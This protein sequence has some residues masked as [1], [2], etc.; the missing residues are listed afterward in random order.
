MRNGVTVRVLTV[1]CGVSVAL[2][3]G[4]CSDSSSATPK[5]QKRLHELFGDADTTERMREAKTVLAYR[6]AGRPREDLTAKVQ[7]RVKSGESIGI[8]PILDGP[9]PMSRQD[10]NE[11]LAILFNARNLS[12]AGPDC[13][14]EPGIALRFQVDEE[15][16]DVL[17]CFKCNQI[18]VIRGKK[19]TFEDNHALGALAPL[20]LRLFPDDTELKRLSEKVRRAGA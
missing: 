10:V 5:Q 19:K 11:A 2:V 3:F 17:L 6:V 12:D 15:T 14:I 13:I 7:S 1:V 8:Y 9:V 18:E 16:I 20:F 4:S